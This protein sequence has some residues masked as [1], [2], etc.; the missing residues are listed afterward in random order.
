MTWI[1]QT[2]VDVN[3]GVRDMH[4]RQPAPA[5]ARAPARPARVQMKRRL[6]AARTKALCTAGSAEKSG[7]RR[8][9]EGTE[10][11]KA[12]YGLIAGNSSHWIRTPPRTLAERGVQRGKNSNQIASLRFRTACHVCFGERARLLTETSE[13]LFAARQTTIPIVSVRHQRNVEKH[14]QGT[15]HS[16]KSRR[17]RRSPIGWVSFIVRHWI[18]SGIQNDKGLSLGY[19]PEPG[20][21]TEFF[22][23]G[24]ETRFILVQIAA[25]YSGW[26]LFQCEK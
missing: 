23:T 18:G 22:A 2:S 9:R 4:A 25:K 20:Y 26:F 24:K 21:L 1:R 7:K 10:G 12:S 6:C 15:S 19:R 14:R 11:K 5:V 16:L 8:R 3:V 13:R 17:L